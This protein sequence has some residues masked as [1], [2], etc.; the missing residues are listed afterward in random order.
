VQHPLPP[1][2]S[3]KA[4]EYVHR[5]FNKEFKNR[6]HN[7]HVTSSKKQSLPDYKVGLGRPDDSSFPLRTVEQFRA[8]ILKHLVEAEK[9]TFQGKLSFQRS[10]CTA[11]LTC[12]GYHFLF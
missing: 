2:L 1:S 9:P 6:H 12:S 10:E 3:V 8:R 7:P 11:G 5:K 4:Q